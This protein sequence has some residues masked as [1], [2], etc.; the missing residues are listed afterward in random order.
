[1]S[2][3]L[4]KHDREMKRINSETP[5]KVFSATAALGVTFAVIAAGSIIIGGIKEGQERKK[6]VEPHLSQGDYMET[7]NNFITVYK[8]QEKS[9]CAGD[10][11]KTIPLLENGQV[12]GLVIYCKPE[13]GVPAK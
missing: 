11:E 1:M 5:W 10:V 8:G 3:R 4:S 7:S 2:E 12:K 13:A 6:L 9:Q